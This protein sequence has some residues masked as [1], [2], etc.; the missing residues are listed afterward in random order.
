MQHKHLI[1]QIKYAFNNVTLSRGIGLHEARALD[2]YQTVTPE[3]KQLDQDI[4]SDWEAIPKEVLEQFSDALTFVDGKGM[5]YLLPA[6]M[7]AHLKGEVIPEPP[8]Y[9]LIP[10]SEDPGLQNYVLQKLT[11]LSKKQQDVVIAFMKETGVDDAK[12]IQLLQ[13]WGKE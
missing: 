7:I 13:F 4:G 12:V 9:Y 2:D 5:R 3:I 6:F 11:C 1:Q 10:S 8:L